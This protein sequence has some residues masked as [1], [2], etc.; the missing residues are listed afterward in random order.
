MRYFTIILG[1]ILIVLGVATLAYQ[2]FSYTTKENV[3]ELKIPAVGELQVT[4]TKQKSFV[5]PPIASGSAIVA[6]II[7]VLAGAMIRKR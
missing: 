3:T 4:E 6:G 1:S 5:I 7:L 2:R